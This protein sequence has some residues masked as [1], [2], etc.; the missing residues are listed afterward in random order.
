[1]AKKTLPFW[2]KKLAQIRTIRGKAKKPAL[3]KKVQAFQPTKLNLFLE[4]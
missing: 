2:R 4:N 1:V 3:P